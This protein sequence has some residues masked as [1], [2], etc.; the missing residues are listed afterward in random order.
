MP[1]FQ[2]QQ[3]QDHQSDYFSASA[4]RLLS[5]NLDSLS[6]RVPSVQNDDKDFLQDFLADPIIKSMIGVSKKTR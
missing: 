2:M 5:K 1:S 4:L 6:N 3:Q